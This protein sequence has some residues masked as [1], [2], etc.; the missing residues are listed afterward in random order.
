MDIMKTMEH[1]MGYL[2]PDKRIVSHENYQA[3]KEA[4]RREKQETEPHLD[5]SDEDKI[6][7]DKY[8]PFDD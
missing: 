2:W 8:W 1:N 7:F 6:I 3:A 5:G 4:I